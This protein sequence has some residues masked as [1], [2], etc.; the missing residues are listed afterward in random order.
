MTSEI[1]PFD[2]VVLGSGTVNTYTRSVKSRFIEALMKSPE[3]NVIFITPEEYNAR[4]EP[5]VLKYIIDEE[6]TVPSFNDSDFGY[7][8]PSKRKARPYWRQGERW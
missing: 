3:Y 1:K 5:D 6:T 2:V 7:T 8:V 4:R